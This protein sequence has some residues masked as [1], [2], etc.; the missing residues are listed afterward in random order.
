MFSRIFRSRHPQQTPVRPRRARLDLESLEDRTVP[1]VF[2]VNTLADLSIAAGVNTATGV[3]NN[4]TGAVTL[5]SAIQAANADQGTNTINLLLPGTYKVQLAGTPGETD[6][7]AGELAI[8]PTAAG[9]GTLTIQ[10]ISG[11]PVAVSGES[12]ARVFDI[13]PNLVTPATKTTVVF[14]NLSIVNGLAQP[15]D[16]AGGSGG[17]IRDQGAVSL[18]LNNCVVANNAATADGGGLSMENTAN[19]PWTLTLNATTVANNHAGDA[20][21]GIE[22]DGTGKVFVNAG[23]VITGN[24][25]VNQGGGIWLDAIENG[26]SVGSATVAFGGVGYV[27][28]PP[29]FFTPAPAGGTTATGMA[30]VTGGSVTAVV[31]TNPGSGYTAPPAITFGMVGP[32]T[33]A[34]ATANPVFQSAT[35]TVTGAVISNNYAGMLGGGI[36]N[37]GTGAVT[38][39]GSTVANNATGGFGGGF[40]D[41]NN[42]GSLTVLS[43]VFLNNAAATGGGA[44][45]SGDPQT[46]ITSSRIQGNSAA[47]N[48]GG[49]LANGVALT[50]LNSTIANNV[51]GGNGGGIELDTT[52][53]IGALG[54]PGSTITDSTITGN[55]TVN[56]GGVGTGGG[57]DAGVT[58]VT[59]AP[60]LGN[61]T[62]GSTAFSGTVLLSFDTVSFNFADSGGGIFFAGFGSTFTIRDAIVARNQADGSGP[63]LLNNTA[64]FTD[65]GHNFVGNTTNA[66]GLTPVATGDPLLG[67]LQNNFGPTIGAPGA[68]FVLQTEALRAGSP[69]LAKGLAVAGSTT[70]ERGITRKATPDV[71]AFETAPVSGNAVF[72]EQVFQDFLHRVGDVNNPNDAGAWVNA[73]TAGVF[74]PTQ[75]VHFISHSAEALDYVVNGLYAK[76]LNRAADPTGLNNFVTFL[77]NGGTE[78]LVIAFLVSSPEYAQLTG[79]TD[80]G[81]IEG[82]YGLLLGRP[83]SMAEVNGWV[84]ALPRLGRLTVALTFLGSAEYR[85]DEVEQ[86]YGF[87]G[88]LAPLTSVVSLLPNLL[89]RT[90]HSGDA[91]ITAWVNS[92]LSVQVI[93]EFFAGSQE[94]AQRALLLTGGVYD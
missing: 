31:V 86:L 1:A 36:G 34:M 85:A 51:A 3:I 61:S 29:V 10:N 77:M 32:N 72:V 74:T 88:D 47:V 60:F 76:V 94:Y 43:S 5:R 68:P 17:G 81:Y 64:G 20:G 19:T 39:T 13:N 44:I 65:G 62:G 16:M 63:D 15:G 12:L 69:A 55:R 22:T 91:E 89:H 58:L 6:N 93:E 25:C 26:G 92:G 37:A 38:I 2:N 42:Q 46:S 23:T 45:Q 56:N 84:G 8:I 78:E 70:D 40:A 66:G 4:S 21:G 87:T 54:L 28:A 83:P 57:I 27:N 90:Q 9:G 48:G 41:Q 35:L 67:P 7:L 33:P 30:V 82:L 24:S 73:L 49:I 75:V 18:T 50:V 53:P 71:G 14:N 59:T 79:G 11:G 52:G 80:A